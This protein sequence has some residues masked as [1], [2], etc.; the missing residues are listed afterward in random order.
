[1]NPILTDVEVI[2]NLLQKV[3]GSVSRSLGQNF[4]ICEEVV[5]ALLMVAG[6]EEAR[7]VVELG[8]GLGAITQRLLG[9]GF[10]VRAIEKDDGFVK[11]LPS[12]VSSAMR[13]KLEVVHD[14][15]KDVSWSMPEPYQLIGNI[16][17]NLSGLIVRRITQLEEAP[18]QAVLLVQREV[19]ERMRCRAPDMNLMSLAV[20]LWGEAKMVMRVP[21]H[22]FWP[23]PRVSSELVVLRPD[24]Q[25]LSVRDRE[26]IMQV[27]RVAFGQKR[28]QLGTSLRSGPFERS[29]IASALQEAGVEAAQRPEE[30][31]VATWTR[32]GLILSQD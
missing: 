9:S 32:L 20:G 26:R 4:L 27:A 7:A 21:P 14:D 1:M 2:K 22:C 17:Y 25:R 3:G 29:V 6:V 8:P 24:G 16:P 10:L 28:K 30:L 13:A 23:Q 5:E 15:L 19:G 11:L 12:V 18:T 31:S